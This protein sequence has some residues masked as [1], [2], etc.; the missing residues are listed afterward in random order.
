M[1]ATTDFTRFSKSP[2]G[3]ITS[4][5]SALEATIASDG[6]GQRSKK[7]AM[8]LCFVFHELTRDMSTQAM[9]S[10]HWSKA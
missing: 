10:C 9:S 5:R 7:A 4:N 3:A 8:A 1:T 6:V 2:R